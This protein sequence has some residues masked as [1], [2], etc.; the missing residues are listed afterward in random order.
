MSS[1]QAAIG[2]LSRIL[3]AMLLVAASSAHGL[4]WSC[5]THAFI[6]GQAGMAHPEIAC[7]PDLSR[8]ENESL[9]GPYHWHNAAPG[10]VVT[11]EYVDK[12]LV[13]T[14]V[15][16]KTG[17]PGPGTVEVRLP[18]PPGVLY[19][20][21]TD[22]YQSLMKAKGWQREY[23]LSV[24]AHYIGDLSQPLH[25]FPYGAEPAADGKRY[26]E[27]GLWARDSHGAF[28]AALDPHLPLDK[29]SGEEFLQMVVPI[30]I[31]SPEDLKKEISRIA[32]RSIALAGKCYAEKRPMNKKEAMEQASLSVSL[33]KAIMKPTGTSP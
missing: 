26:P 24:I 32:N 3:A 28:D 23:Y 29:D 17:V 2:S 16:V 11:P 13:R 20:I 12:F 1:R 31:A 10:T 9:L 22:L 5:K 7:F 25:N 4:A 8:H 21:I 18:D 15:L 33:L 19:S 6:A 27:A 14:G 30:A